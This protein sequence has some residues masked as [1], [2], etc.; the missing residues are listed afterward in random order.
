M[1][2]LLSTPK[3]N[4]KYFTIL[5]LSMIL[6][7]NCTQ[8]KKEDTHCSE[9]ELTSITFIHDNQL[10]DPVFLC[11]TDSFLLIT[12]QKADT[13]IDVFNLNGYKTSN[14]LKRGEGPGEGLYVVR[15]QYDHKRK[16]IYA[17]D[18]SKNTLFKFTNISSSKPQIEHLLS[19]HKD[20]IDQT[21]VHNWWG[22][23]K[24]DEI[25]AGN[26]TPKGM[27]AVYTRNG[28]LI[29]VMTPYPDKNQ[30][31]ERLTE[32][33]N[34][35]LYKP[36]GSISPYGDKAIITNSIS[37]M[38]SWVTFSKEGEVQIKTQVKAVPND[39]YI[40][41][42]G[43]NFVQGALTE[44]T[45]RYACD[46][47]SG[48]NHVYILYAGTNGKNFSKD[49]YQAR[50]IHVYNWSGELHKKLTLDKPARAISVSP[51]E[52]ILYTIN[53]SSETGYSILKYEL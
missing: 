33:A 48:F 10:N 35:M 1:L 29:K 47:T 11:V 53:E 51:D 27:Y 16:C 18:V 36:F 30:T 44:K 39:I 7:S 3:G 41:Q 25:I 42:S 31:D 15:L 34:I 43:E 21:L 19:F 17:P 22:Y 24:N 28:K 32:W 2:S 12:N 5:L 40:I 23:L 26:A 37:D 49:E 38:L 50:H 13:I 46:I 20:T 14:F 52:K 4:M 9:Q 8:Q 45:M 6:F